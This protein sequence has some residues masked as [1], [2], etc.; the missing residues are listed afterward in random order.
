VAGCGG[1]G[2]GGRGGADGDR[3]RPPPDRWRHCATSSRRYPRRE[4][5]LYGDATTEPGPCRGGGEG[6]RPRV[7]PCG[8]GGVD[9]AGAAGEDVTGRIEAT[10][11]RTRAERAFGLSEGERIPRMR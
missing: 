11:R 5:D 2:G 3:G 1:G 4:R 10:R 6:G 8:G 7:E 9:C